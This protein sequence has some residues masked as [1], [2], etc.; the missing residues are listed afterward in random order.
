MRPV[1]IL[2][3]ASLLFAIVLAPACNRTSESSVSGQGRLDIRLTDAPID[4][5]TVASV[6]VNIDEVLVYPGVQE[7]DG[8]DTPPIVVSTHPATFDLLTLTGGAST[9]L[10][11]ANL[12]AGFY[13]RIRLNISSA[14]LTF[15]DGTTAD[16]MIESHKVDVP[17]RFE[18][19]VSDTT[20]VTLDFQAAASVQVNGT[21]SGAYILRPVVTPRP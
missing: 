16:L 4:L 6:T 8:T 3:T 10:A 2:S 1:S 7:M 13:Q 14:S 19:K 5:S 9:L 15:K 18:V 17:I 21:A 12:P 20:Q 11:S